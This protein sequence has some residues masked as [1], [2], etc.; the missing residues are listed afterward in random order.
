MNRIQEICRRRGITRICH[1]TQSRNLAHIFDEPYG[2]HS[3]RTLKA[4]DIP[5]NPTDLER[6]DGRDDLVCCSIEYPN[7]YYFSKVRD[8]ERL[9]PDWVVLY[10][11]QTFLWHPDTRFCPCNAAKARGK[12]IHK[13]VK[14]FELLFAQ[15]S[16]AI[17]FAR[18]PSHLSSAPT[19]IQAEVLV[20]DPI[21]LDSI[22]GIAVQSH[23]QA[24]REIF[25]LSLQ[26]I[27]LNKPVFIAPDFYDRAKISRL[28][29]AGIRAKETSYISGGHYD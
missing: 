26:G 17:T 1:F 24:Q 7:T 28:I 6:Y 11:D 22:A 18:K 25:R 21:P 12:Y 9:F 14:G 23:G 29:Q 2:L 5:H 16:P 20:P 3:T 15:T 8:K 13:E 10:I 27:L 19:D 4:N